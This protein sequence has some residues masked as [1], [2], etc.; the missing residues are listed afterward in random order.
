MSAF[1]PDGAPHARARRPRGPARRADR[2]PRGPRA[3]SASSSRA[4]RSAARSPWRAANQARSRMAVAGPSR[5]AGTWEA[6]P[7]P[8]R[9]GPTRP[10][11]PVGPARRPGPRAGGSGRR[12]ASGRP[13]RTAQGASPG[14]PFPARPGRPPG[15]RSRP[16]EELPGPLGRERMRLERVELAE[17]PERVGEVVE[18]L[19]EQVDRLVESAL[20]ARTL[21]LPRAL[22]GVRPRLASDLVEVVLAVGESAELQ[23]R[24]WHAGCTANPPPGVGG[25]PPRLEGGVGPPLAC[26]QRPR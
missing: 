16:L 12:R 25:P 14:R 8:R 6:P 3:D 4:R 2:G 5:S 1:R 21:Q 9:D 13:R 17:A 7:S 26:S 22:E 20:R 10:P 19:L 24:A 15:P 11:I 18:P 23:I